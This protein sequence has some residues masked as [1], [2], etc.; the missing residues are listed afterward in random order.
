MYTC[1]NA[2]FWFRLMLLK[3][4]KQTAA[5]SHVCDALLATDFVTVKV[6]ACDDCLKPSE[7]GTSN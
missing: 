4:L 5:Y 1:K 6:E 3:S 2:Y 7:A